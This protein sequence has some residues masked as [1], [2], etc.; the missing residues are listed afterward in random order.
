[1]AK[2]D[3]GFDDISS[4]AAVLP[5]VYLKQA[6]LASTLHVNCSQ[7]TAHIRSA[8]TRCYHSDK[9]ISF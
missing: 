2:D 4:D 8:K 5:V 6:L 7:M 3:G 1:M 9:N